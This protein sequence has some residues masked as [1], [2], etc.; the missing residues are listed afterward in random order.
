VRDVANFHEAI[1]NTDLPEATVVVD[2][3]A[4]LD[5][6]I[7]VLNVHRTTGDAPI[8]RFLGRARA[9]VLA[10]SWWA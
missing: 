8:R 1:T 2:D 4:S 3:A 9:S 7:D 10:V 5:A 6:A